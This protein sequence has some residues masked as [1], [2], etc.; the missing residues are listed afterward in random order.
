MQFLTILRSPLDSALQQ[1]K[2]GVTVM[3][4]RVTE[5]RKGTGVVA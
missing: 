4:M 2:D 5:T 3:M 1:L